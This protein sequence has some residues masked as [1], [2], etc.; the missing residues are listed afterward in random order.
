MAEIGE[1]LRQRHPNITHIEGDRSQ[2]ETNSRPN[3]ALFNEW[4]NYQRTGFWMPN[5]GAEEA[6]SYR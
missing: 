3:N 5:Y 6:G 2:N 4:A 1:N